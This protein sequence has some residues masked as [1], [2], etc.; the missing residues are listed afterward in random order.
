MEKHGLLGNRYLRVKIAVQSSDHKRELLSATFAVIDFQ[1]GGG[2]IFI[3]FQVAAG[4][5]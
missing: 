2:I 4:V 5:N 1:A 3:D